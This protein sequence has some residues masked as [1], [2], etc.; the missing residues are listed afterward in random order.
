MASSL[1]GCCERKEDWS[2]V[3]GSLA[4]ATTSTIDP[5]SLWQIQP[6]RDPDEICTDT[7]LKIDD[8]GGGKSGACTW[9]ANPLALQAWLSF[10][11]PRSKPPPNTQQKTHISQIST[12]ASEFPNQH[13]AQ[14]SDLGSSDV[15]CSSPTN[16]KCWKQRADR[17][18]AA[19]V[20]WE[21]SGEPGKRH[22]G[23]REEPKGSITKY[24]EIPP[25]FTHSPSNLV[26]INRHRSASLPCI[27]FPE[28]NARIHRGVVVDN[29]QHVGSS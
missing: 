26:S 2:T 20:I 22:T 3:S 9:P 5:R 24:S 23:S 12:T 6:M 11:A 4:T 18:T 27:L 16:T 15:R 10:L 7:P 17:P 14:T 1:S 13:L 29:T 25:P 21:G 19:P 28:N 8:G